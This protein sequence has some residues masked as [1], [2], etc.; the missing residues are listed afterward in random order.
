MSHRPSGSPIRKL[1]RPV[2]AKN[3]V[4][5]CTVREGRDGVIGNTVLPDAEQVVS[6]LLACRQ[7]AL[8]ARLGADGTASEIPLVVRR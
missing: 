2:R 4:L 1:P 7:D 8:T 3:L 6:S 5:L